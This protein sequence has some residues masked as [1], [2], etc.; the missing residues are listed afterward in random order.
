[1]GILITL[2]T[3]IQTF[4]ASYTESVHLQQYRESLLQQGYIHSIEEYKQLFTSGWRAKY[5]ELYYASE[6][7]KYR[8]GMI[9]G[10]G[11]KF[12]WDALLRDQNQNQNHHHQGLGTCSWDDVHKNNPNANPNQRF[13][14][15]SSNPIVSILNAFNSDQFAYARI[16]LRFALILL[17]FFTMVQNKWN[18]LHR[19]HFNVME[20]TWEFRSRE[21]R[22]RDRG[23]G[24]EYD[25]YGEMPGGSE[26][27]QQYGYARR[28]ARYPS[29]RSHTHSHSYPYSVSSSGTGNRNRNRNWMS[30]S[31][32]DSVVD[33]AG[34]PPWIQYS[35]QVNAMRK[36]RERERGTRMF[37]SIA[38]QGIL[39]AS[40]SSSQMRRSRNRDRAHRTSGYDQVYGDWGY[41]DLDTQVQEEYPSYE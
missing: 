4:L 10:G 1:M 17:M 38:S 20:K 33:A 5:P 29:S 6:M 32:L 23:W 18:P 16:F 21:Q 9:Q 39:G 12:A 15:R 31:G 11:G 19:K 27:Q 3:A 14:F 30:G 41:G 34:A 8:D 25:E 28:S 35:D 24:T 22:D 13:K 26:N 2:Y 36:D 40:S 37:D 7:Q